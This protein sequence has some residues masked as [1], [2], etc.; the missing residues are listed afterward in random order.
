MDVVK[1]IEGTKT[2]SRGPYQNVPV[3]SVVI[4]SAKVI[5]ESK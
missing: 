4:T 3:D 2:G 5:H 1:K